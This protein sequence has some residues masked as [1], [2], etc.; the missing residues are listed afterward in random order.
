MGN[1]LLATGPGTATAPYDGSDKMPLDGSW[2]HGRG[3]RVSDDLDP[4]T[5]EIMR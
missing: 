5:K 1:A 2:S 3:G 4:Y